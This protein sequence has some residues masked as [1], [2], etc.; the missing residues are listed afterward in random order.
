M[1]P[2]SSLLDI[3]ID[4]RA[5]AEMGPSESGTIAD[6]KI[7]CYF[8]LVLKFCPL[9][10]TQRM[11]ESSMAS[12]YCLGMDSSSVCPYFFTRLELYNGI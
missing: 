5:A 9:N 11:Q 12:K 10:H 7:L 8:S 3:V 1:C 4:W 6:A 2:V